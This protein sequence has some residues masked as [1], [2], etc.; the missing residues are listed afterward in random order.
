MV[1]SRSQP[2]ETPSGVILSEAKDLAHLRDVFRICEVPRL[3]SG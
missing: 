2:I 3:R 1:A